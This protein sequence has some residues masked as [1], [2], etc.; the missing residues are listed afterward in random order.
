[1]LLSVFKRSS[2][3]ILLATIITTLLI[4]GK[5]IYSPQPIL[6]FQHYEMPLFALVVGLLNGKAWLSV[7]VAIAF[8]MLSAFYLI[9]LNTRH[10]IIK[11]R[12]YL[13]ALIF[14][15]IAS[16][17][18]PLQ[19]IN[20]AMLAT[21]F[22][23]FSTNY[24][25]GIYEGKNSLDRLFRGGLLLGI[26][27]LFYLPFVIFLLFAFIGII[28]LG[29]ANIRQWFSLIFGFIAPWAFTF[30]YYFLR[31]G[32]VE[33]LVQIIVNTFVTAPVS[34]DLNLCFIIFYSFIGLL[35][36]IASLFLIQSMSTQKISVRKFY[37]LLLW[38]I[39]I[40]IGVILLTGFSSIEMIY[41]IAFPS[42]I[43][44]ANYFSTARNKFWPKFL[45]TIL[46]LS[47]IACQFI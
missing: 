11:Q 15:I 41:I 45:F 7:L 13:P 36:I 37:A 35:G 6:Y 39:P 9:F 4:W 10:I 43:F 1:M 34:Y 19:A 29:N 28:I 26:G 40:A 38:V 14:I 16:T 12:S 18:A 47:S 44:I 5:S 42:A 2:A 20:P 17:F 32:S 33:S 23:I 3:S 22:L 27:S 46:L 21:P 24:L 25:F 31:F 30:A 8:T